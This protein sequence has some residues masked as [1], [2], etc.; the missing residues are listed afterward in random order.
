MK[1]SHFMQKNLIG[2]LWKEFYYKNYL[3]NKRLVFSVLVMIY[4]MKTQL[5]FLLKV[6]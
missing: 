5:Q 3:R 4:N 6:S 1:K 2:S